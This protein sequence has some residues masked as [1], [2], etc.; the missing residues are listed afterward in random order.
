MAPFDGILTASSFA[1][2]SASILIRHNDPNILAYTL[3]GAL[4]PVAATGPTTGI[5]VAEGEVVG[6]TKSF[7]YVNPYPLLAKCTVLI[8]SLASTAF[9]KEGKV[10]EAPG[11]LER[12]FPDAFRKGSIG[13]VAL[14]PS[15]VT[16]T[17]LPPKYG[18]DPP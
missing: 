11:E 18:G 7:G 16:P 8:G 2:G 13:T 6:H 3:G 5:H 1:N 17:V 10:A 4:V 15:T 14:P 9:T 12:L